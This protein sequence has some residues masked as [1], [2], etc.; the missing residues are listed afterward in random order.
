MRFA[1][2]SEGLKT[3]QIQQ[4]SLSP[5]Q[6]AK[7]AELHFIGCY[8]HLGFFLAFSRALRQWV[9]LPEAGICTCH[10]HRRMCL[11]MEFVTYVW[12]SH[13]QNGKSQALGGRRN[14]RPE[15]SALEWK[16]YQAPNGFIFVFLKK[17]INKGKV[18]REEVVVSRRTLCICA[19]MHAYICIYPSI[20]TH[21]P[22]YEQ[23]A[24]LRSQ[25]PHLLNVTEVW[26]KEK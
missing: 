13:S 15:P 7:L 18:E 8:P 11:R 26:I 2:G 12:T 24:S 17:R 22:S 19:W 9:L 6:K 23:E 25:F 10:P 3:P 14:S 21:T 20:Y 4:E 1:N 16:S 5:A